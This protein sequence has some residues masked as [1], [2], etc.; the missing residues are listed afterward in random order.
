MD[1]IVAG[2]LLAV[3]FVNGIDPERTSPVVM[4]AS[5]KLSLRAFS[6]EVGT[7]SAKKMRQNQETRAI[8]DST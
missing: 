4:E 1:S 7:G 6:A 2:S 8:S 3:D 5:G